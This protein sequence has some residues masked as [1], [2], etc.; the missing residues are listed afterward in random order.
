MPRKELTIEKVQ[1]IRFLDS[2]GFPH[3]A[4]RW[5]TGMSKSTIWDVANYKTWKNVQDGDFL[6]LDAIATLRE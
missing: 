2:I 3:V 1:A 4:I 5:M 6:F